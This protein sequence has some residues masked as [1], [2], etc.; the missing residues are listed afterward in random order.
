MKSFTI[1]FVFIVEIQP[2]WN[3]VRDFAKTTIRGPPIDNI[4]K[5]GRGGGGE[6]GIRLIS[7]VECEETIQK[8]FKIV[9]IAN[10]SQSLEQFEMMLKLQRFA[11]V[12]PGLKP[13]RNELIAL[14]DFND[15]KIECLAAI[16]WNKKLFP[17]EMEVFML[18]NAPRSIEDRS[19]DMMNFIVDMCLD[20]GILAIFSRLE[21]YDHFQQ[22]KF[23]E[24]LKHGSNCNDSSCFID[25]SISTMYRD[26]NKAPLFCIDMVPEANHLYFRDIGGPYWFCDKVTHASKPHLSTNF[27]FRQK[28]PGRAYEYE[29]LFLR[30]ETGTSHGSGTVGGALIVE[31]DESDQIL[32]NMDKDIVLTIANAI[33]R[34][35]VHPVL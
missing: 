3:L 33:K 21:K 28:I 1:L 24:F 2:V 35:V 22:A 14:G 5:S 25:D 11:E 29:I 31:V 7:K 13:L 17:A 34:K 8:W 23:S 32:P 15:G 6:N 9:G 12:M 27:Y 10:G 20:N 30:P 4:I 19:V 26:V 18:V 16:C